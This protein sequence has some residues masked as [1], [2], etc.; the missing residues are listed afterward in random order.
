M[1]ITLVQASR[2]VKVSV[3]HLEKWCEVTMDRS[4]LPTPPEPYA[5]ERQDL[6]AEL[7]AAAHALVLRAV[8]RKSSPWSAGPEHVSFR[9]P[10]EH[11]RAVVEA[12]IEIEDGCLGYA[13]DWLARDDA[14]DSGD[15]V[16]SAA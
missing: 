12:L 13:K 14:P 11:W 9:C 7:A 15:P 10:I 4:A 16:S 1:K 6:R 8:K 5:T 3:L 2:T